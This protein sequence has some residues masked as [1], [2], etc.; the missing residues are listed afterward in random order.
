MAAKLRVVHYLNQFFAQLGSEEEASIGIMTENKPIGPGISIQKELGDRA[1]IVGTIICGDNYIAENLDEVTAEILNVIE[2]YSPDMFFAGPAFNAGRYGVACGAICTA[3]NKK[4]GIPV[5][6]AMFEENP[7]REIFQRDI[8]ILKSGDTARKM[9]EETKKMV[10]F[11]FKLKDGTVEYDPDKE[12]FFDRGLIVTRKYEDMASTRAINMLLNK[13]H[14]R[15]FRTEIP[16][17]RE[18]KVE[19]PHPVPDLSKAIVML[20]TDGGLC[21]VGNPDGM[22]TGGS[23]V[24]NAYSV[25]GKDSL[26]K[27]DF[28]CVHGGFDKSFVL[29]DPNRLVPLDAMRILEKEG[30]VKMHDV[31]LST[32]GLAT[33]KESSIKMGR[34]MVTYIKDHN[35][36]A[37]IMTST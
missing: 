29:E 12:D 31:F 14:G 13:I 22:R 11:A 26:S 17:S 32:A 21:P 10:D 20:A 16:L 9:A 27:E 4:L 3:L 7:G 33:G 36:D 23:I 1:D 35:I 8:F 30:F 25:E 15:P 28:T 2:S 18:E 34:E 6:T 37:V 5:I 24:F 19:A